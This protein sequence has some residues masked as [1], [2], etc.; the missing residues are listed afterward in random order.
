MKF[1]DEYRFLPHFV[2]RNIQNLVAQIVFELTRYFIRTFIPYLMERYN[3]ESY[4]VLLERK[5]D[6]S[7]LK[8]YYNKYIYRYLLYFS[9]I[10]FFFTGIFNMIIYLIIR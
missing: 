10:F 3:I 8:A 4:I 9:L 5:G 1:L 7:I 6:I 2:K